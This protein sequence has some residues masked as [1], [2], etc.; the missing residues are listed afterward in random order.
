MHSVY[1]FAGQSTACPGFFANDILPCICSK[2][3]LLFALSE[4]AIPY[5]PITDGPSEVHILP[6]SA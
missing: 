3:S 1:C 6:L 2:E 5:I 4:V